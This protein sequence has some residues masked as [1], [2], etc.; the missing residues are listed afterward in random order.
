MIDQTVFFFF[1]RYDHNCHISDL[2]PPIVMVHEYY[3][4][5]NKTIRSIITPRPRE[6]RKPLAP[7]FIVN[8]FDSNILLQQFGT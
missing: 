2:I 3:E 6:T 7:L 4:K 5:R 8:L 1:L